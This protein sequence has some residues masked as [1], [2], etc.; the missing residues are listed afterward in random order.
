MDLHSY[1]VNYAGVPDLQQQADINR[2][3]MFQVPE[4]DEEVVTVKGSED[5]SEKDGSENSEFLDAID[6]APTKELMNTINVRRK[7]TVMST[8]FSLL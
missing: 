6:T 5:G 1:V 8:R 2:K 7:M 4:S 3:L